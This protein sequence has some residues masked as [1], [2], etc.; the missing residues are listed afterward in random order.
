MSTSQQRENKRQ[1]FNSKMTGL[2]L[3]EQKSS[4]LHEHWGHPIEIQGLQCF[5]GVK[6]WKEGKKTGDQQGLERGDKTSAG[7]ICLTPL[8]PWTSDWL[9][10]WRLILFNLLVCTWQWFGLGFLCEWINLFEENITKGSGSLFNAFSI[11][12]AV[13]ETLRVRMRLTYWG[14]GGGFLCWATRVLFVLSGAVGFQVSSGWAD[15][16]I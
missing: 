11:R 4:A 3:A 10:T 15:G 6:K 12:L 14:G 2:F 16:L 13:T 5:H 7:T 8:L 1:F 9:K